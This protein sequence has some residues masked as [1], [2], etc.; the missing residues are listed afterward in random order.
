MSID[1]S[2]GA[3]ALFF[4]LVGASVLADVCFAIEYADPCETYITARVHGVSPDGLPA[5]Y[6]QTWCALR[7]QGR[8]P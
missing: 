5:D 4:L 3:R 1:P 7:K 8:G 2:S 6:D